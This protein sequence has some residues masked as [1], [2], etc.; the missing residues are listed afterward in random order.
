MIHA[1][2]VVYRTTTNKLI[3]LMSFYNICITAY[4]HETSYDLD[5]DFQRY[6]I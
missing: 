1:L 2:S 6:D 4:Q 3:E 5:Y